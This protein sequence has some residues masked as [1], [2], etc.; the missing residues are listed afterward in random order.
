VPVLEVFRLQNGQ[1]AGRRYDRRTRFSRRYLCDSRLHSETKLW[2]S[3]SAVWHGWHWHVG[4]SELDWEH[5]I[6]AID[7]EVR[8][9]AA[10]YR[11]FEKAGVEL[12]QSRFLDPHTLEVDGR[13][14]TADKILIAVASFKPNLPGMEYAIT[15]N[16]MF[17]LPKQ[18]VLLALYWRWWNLLTS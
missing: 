9:L 7:K 6:T 18:T 17:H 3:S 16:Q 8:R 5:F 4:K 10:T 14:I 13:K 12:I 15:S 11:V 1:L 2:I